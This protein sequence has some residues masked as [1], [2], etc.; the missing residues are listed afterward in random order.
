MSPFFFLFAWG[1]LVAKASGD[2]RVLRFYTVSA[3]A[4]RHSPCLSSISSLSREDTTVS[5]S[6]PLLSVNLSSIPI[7]YMLSSAQGRTSPLLSTLCPYIT[8]LN[9]R[10]QWSQYLVTAPC[11]LSQG[12]LKLSFESLLW[13]DLRIRQSSPKATRHWQLS[14]RNSP[15]GLHP[16]SS[17]FCQDLTQWSSSWLPSLASHPKTPFE[18]TTYLEFLINFCVMG[19][20]HEDFFP[21]HC[22][23]CYITSSWNTA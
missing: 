10:L 3:A 1:L 13:A 4:D 20:P 6:P 8:S 12:L 5:C 2:Y 7:S 9:T 16:D 18:T 14:M 17:S 19:L 11:V 21:P 23:F 15:T 22:V